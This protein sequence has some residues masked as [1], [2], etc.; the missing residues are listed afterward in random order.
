VGTIKRL[1]VGATVS[2]GGLSVLLACAAVTTST[3][4]HEGVPYFLPLTKVRYLVDLEEPAE[5]KIETISVPDRSRPLY[6]SYSENAFADENICVDRTED[7]LLRKI[8][9]G[10]HDRLPDVILN[11][12]EVIAQ[13]G[14]P[15][16]EEMRSLERGVTRAECSGTVISEWMDPYDHEALRRFNA[17]LCG[18]RVEVPDFSGGAALPTFQCPPY[19]VCFATNSTFQYSLR[20][21]GGRIFRQEHATVASRRDIGFISVKTATFNKR[22]TLLDFTDGALTTVRIRKDSEM[23]GLSELPINAVERVLAVP[24]NA[25]GMAF[26]GYQ[27]RL[28]YLKQ[29]KALKEAGAEG[30]D[31]SQDPYAGLATAVAACVPPGDAPSP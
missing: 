18:Y 23:L 30:S 31:A 4:V 29:R 24:G 28:L 3:S 26:A 11:V 12:L 10:S 20:G 19:G 5:T 6:L 2:I 16:A 13:G 17:T 27:E 8:Y 7:G 1:A 21:P 25:I 22:I 9:F 15:V 14:S